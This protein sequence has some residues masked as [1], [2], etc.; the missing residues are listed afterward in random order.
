MFFH[1]AFVSLLVLIGLAAAVLGAMVAFG[2]GD[3]PPPLAAIAKA[4]EN[5][6]FTGLPPTQTVPARAGRTIAY[7]EWDARS[8]SLPGTV[9]IA[10]HGSAGSS[11]SLH[12]LAKALSRHGI[13]VYAPD[14]RGHGETGKPGDIDYSGQLDDDLDDFVTAIQ[15]LYPGQR[16]VVL[17][18]SLGGG[19]ALHSAARSGKAFKRAVLLSPML[20]P[21][22]PTVK[23][24]AHSWASPFI[25]RIVA[26][27]ALN[28]LGFHSFDALPAIAF[29]IDPAQARFVT[30]RYSFRLMR[31][32][33]TLDYAADLKNASVPVAI[34]AGAKDELFDA[35]LFAP[36]VHAVRTDIPVT[37]IPDVDHAGMITDPRAVPLIAASLRG[38][39]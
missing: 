24:A 15:R 19:F 20:G 10:I 18:F 6:D 21:Q 2:A 33:G 22:A 11:T 30:A 39:S 36:A 31:E 29:A 26:I 27:R 17:G 38:H 32:F 12:P 37:V 14:I 16:P 3:A 9:V 8:A 28:R 5:A 4:F 34:L 35:G 25:P 13:P 1:R 7:R 23:E